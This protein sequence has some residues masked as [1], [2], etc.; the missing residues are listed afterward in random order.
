[1]NELFAQVLDISLAAVLESFDESLV[2]DI[3]VHVLDDNSK[4]AFHKTRLVKSISAHYDYKAERQRD[5]K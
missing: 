4:W 5:V 1:V 3:F 2:G